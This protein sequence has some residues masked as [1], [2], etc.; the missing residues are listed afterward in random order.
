MEIEV[1]AIVRMETS[2]YLKGDTKDEVYLIYAT[3]HV[4]TPPD[5]LTVSHGEPPLT[6]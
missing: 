5:S 1:C 6:K 4:L 2:I 3:T